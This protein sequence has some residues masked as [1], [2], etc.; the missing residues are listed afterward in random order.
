V[1]G[2]P[3]AKTSLP[4]LPQTFKRIFVVPEDIADHELPS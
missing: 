2:Y 4:E 1:P 3:T